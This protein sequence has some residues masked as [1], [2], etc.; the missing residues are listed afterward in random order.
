MIVAPV[1]MMARGNAPIPIMEIAVRIGPVTLS[2]IRR[3]TRVR[4]ISTAMMGPLTRRFHG[5]PFSPDISITPTDQI[6]VSTPML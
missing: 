2:S 3:V 4:P 5:M 6:A 1:I